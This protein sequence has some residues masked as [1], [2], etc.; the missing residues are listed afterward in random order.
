MGLTDRVVRSY[1]WSQSVTDG[2]LVCL[3]KWEC[4]RQIGSVTL[5]R[6][7]NGVPC[8]L[9]AQPGGT[10]MRIQTDAQFLDK[11]NSK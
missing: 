6:G 5:N 11:K 8:L 1:R 4:A 9:V 10:F 7:C 2:K 3:N